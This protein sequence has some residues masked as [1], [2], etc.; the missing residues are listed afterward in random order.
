MYASSQPS[1]A[2]DAVRAQAAPVR[3]PAGLPKRRDRREQ[4]REPGRGRRGVLDDEQVAVAGED[5]VGEARRRRHVVRREPAAVDVEAHLA[6]V[7]RRDVRVRAR[8]SPARAPASSGERYSSSR[9]PSSAR[10]RMLSSIPKMTSPWGSPAVSSALLSVSFASPPWRIRSGQAGLLLERLLDVLRDGERVVRDEHDVL[11]LRTAPAAARA[12]HGARRRRARPRRARRLQR[13]CCERSHGAVPPGRIASRTPCGERHAGLG[14]REDVRH[15][16]GRAGLERLAVERVLEPEVVTPSAAPPSGSSVTSSPARPVERRSRCARRG[17]ARRRRSA[18]SS[19][20]RVALRAEQEE[21]R[22]EVVEAAAR[23]RDRR[24]RGAPRARAASSRASSRSVASFATGMPDDPRCRPTRPLASAAEETRVEV[25][26]D[27]VDLEPERG[28]AIEAA[29]G[30]DH[31]RLRR[32]RRRRGPAP[33]RRPRRPARS[34]VP[35][36]ALPRSG[37]AGRRRV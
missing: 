29:V 2:Q 28:R 15:A 9:S 1:T 6:V 19:S 34:R 18:S 4:E 31:G 13:D 12:E 35:P 5:E 37:S 20:S 26:D 32:A 21:R 17:R 3:L 36:L 24:A 11:R 7:D 33:M 14:R 10:D 16:A 23:A 25:A 27:D 22:E 8:R 30:R